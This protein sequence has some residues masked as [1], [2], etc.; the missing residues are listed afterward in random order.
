MNKNP[1]HDVSVDKTD[2][3][4]KNLNKF[5][6]SIKIDIPIYTK[7][8]LLKISCVDYNKH[9]KTLNGYSQYK[10]ANPQQF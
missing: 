1:R 8:E 6:D 2:T 3:F 4:H 9:L 10:L 5:I 7:K